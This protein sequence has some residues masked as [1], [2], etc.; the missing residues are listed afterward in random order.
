MI[1]LKSQI[2]ILNSNQVDPSEIKKALNEYLNSD[3]SKTKGNNGSHSDKSE[4]TSGKNNETGKY[5]MISPKSEEEYDNYKDVANANYKIVLG[6]YQ[7]LSYAK[8]Y[9]KFLKREI[10]YDTKLVQLPNQQLNYI[11][12]CDV[13]EYSTL[14]EALKQLSRTRADVKTKT[15]KITHGEAWILQTLND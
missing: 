12:V 11:Y 8:A 9:Q 3:E 10:G 4:K 2:E 5:K 14:K 15:V 1:L 7:P 6:V 13:N